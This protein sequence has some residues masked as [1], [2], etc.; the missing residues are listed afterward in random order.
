MRA[1]ASPASAPPAP[2]PPTPP[3]KGEESRA[4]LPLMAKPRDINLLY[5]LEALAWDGYQAGLGALSVKAAGD[6]GAGLLPAISPLVSANKTA[7][8]NLRMAYPQESEAW[9]RE[10][11]R[12]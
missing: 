4:A 1:A 11:A 12:A 7:L 5:R 9:R 10:V 2:P 8:R 6:L 3:C